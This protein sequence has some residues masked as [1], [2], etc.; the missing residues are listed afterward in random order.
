MKFPKHE[1]VIHPEQMTLLDK[2]TGRIRATSCYYADKR[3]WTSG[4]LVMDEMTI[5]QIFTAIERA[6]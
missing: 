1:F 6:Y 2:R 4:E 5:H 3:L